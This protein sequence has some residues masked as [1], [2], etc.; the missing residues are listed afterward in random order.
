[1]KRES[2]RRFEEPSLVHA[3]QHPLRRALVVTDKNGSLYSP[4]AVSL[5]KTTEFL[6]HIIGIHEANGESQIW[7]RC[8][9]G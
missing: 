4:R 5:S 6:H 9:S 2:Q 8:E 1:M 7:E 3:S